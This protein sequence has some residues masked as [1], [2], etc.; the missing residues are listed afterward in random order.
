M[1]LSFLLPTPHFHRS[2]SL[3]L[4]LIIVSCS[5][6]SNCAGAP[7]GGG[8][9]GAGDGGGGAGAGGA[10]SRAGGFLY[11]CLPPPAPVKRSFEVAA[12]NDRESVLIRV[13]CVCGRLVLLCYTC[14][15]VK[16]KDNYIP[17]Q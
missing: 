16:D 2:L 4:K 14:F 7:G 13:R 17:Y 10:G 6:A 12:A 11:R 8:G 15:K 5:D 1:H 3:S 9:G